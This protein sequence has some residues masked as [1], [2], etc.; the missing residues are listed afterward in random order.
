MR[1]VKKSSFMASYKFRHRSKESFFT[2]DKDQKK[3]VFSL[4]TQPFSARVHKMRGHCVKDP[5]A[6]NSIEKLKGKPTKIN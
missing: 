5:N 3:G 1:Y 4:F 2:D 6:E